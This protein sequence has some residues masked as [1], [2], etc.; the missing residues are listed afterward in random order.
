MPSLVLIK[1]LWGAILDSL[2]CTLYSQD[3]SLGAEFTF[4]DM[5]PLIL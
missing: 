2:T 3:L 5:D 1:A 4:T